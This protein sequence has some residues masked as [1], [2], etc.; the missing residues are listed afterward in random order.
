M[1]F[2]RLQKIGVAAVL[3]ARPNLALRDIN[4][5]LP[6]AKR[7]NNAFTDSLDREHS[8]TDVRYAMAM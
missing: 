2:I 6:S 7:G 4:N 3:D 1:L 8:V 5:A